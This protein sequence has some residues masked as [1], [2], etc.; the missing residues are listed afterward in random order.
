MPLAQ[1]QEEAQYACPHCAGRLALIMHQ[2]VTGLMGCCDLP[3]AQRVRGV[4]KGEGLLW[5][6]LSEPSRHQQASHALAIQLPVVLACHHQ[7]LQHGAN[8]DWSLLLCALVSAGRLADAG[9]NVGCCCSRPQQPITVCTPSKLQAL[10]ILALACSDGAGLMG[11][12]RPCCTWTDL[13][14]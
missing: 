4:R 13:S 11:P 5:E 12:A 2:T 8:H 6:R 1:N 3:F 7:N 10:F 14:R 9:E